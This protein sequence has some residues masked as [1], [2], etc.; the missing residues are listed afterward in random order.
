MKSFVES[1]SI[2]HDQKKL[3]ER[4]DLDGYLFFRDIVNKDSITNVRSDIANLLWS[5]G[6][7]DEG[8]EPFEA[9]TTQEAHLNN[10]EKYL[11]VYD[12]I[13]KIQSF[14][15]LAHD[16][17]VMSLISKILDATAIPHPCKNARLMFPSRQEHTTPPHQDFPLIQG[18]PDVWTVWIPLGACPAELGGL[19]V[20]SGSH[21]TGVFPTH[22][23][24][25]AGISLYDEALKEEKWVTSPFMKGD[26][27]F[28]HSHTI[29][30][31][32]PNNSGNLMRLS[33]DYRYQKS[34]DPFMEDLLMP[35]KNR[36]SWEEVYRD[37]KSDEYKYYWKDLDLKTVVRKAI[38]GTG[39]P[40]DK[41]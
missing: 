14:H 20:Q 35:H 33:V 8:T 22:K 16:A 7:L 15:A 24:G 11:P 1:N 34:T 23:A 39:I 38:A 27:L 30:K 40:K 18:T 25:P 21:K 19:V 4:A 26:A 41:Y 6:W 10:T 9:K 36:L 28:F 29:H 37:W 17:G 5:N 3:I 13:Q 31:A 12:S 32:L 2:I